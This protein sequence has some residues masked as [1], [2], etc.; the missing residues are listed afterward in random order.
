MSAPMKGRLKQKKNGGIRCRC[1]EARNLNLGN[2][3]K[4]ALQME[5]WAKQEALTVADDSKWKARHFKKCTKSIVISRQ[6]TIAEIRQSRCLT[7]PVQK[8]KIRKRALDVLK[9]I[10]SVCLTESLAVRMLFNAQD[11]S[12][13][14]FRQ[15][16]GVKCL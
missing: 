15:G 2:S 11:S 3:A 1:R 4:Q 14:S 5:S 9:K 13:K 7:A 8:R 6:P 12:A 10:K 16:N